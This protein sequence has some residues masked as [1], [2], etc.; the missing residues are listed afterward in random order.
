MTYTVRRSRALSILK[1]LRLAEI[2]RL[3][4]RLDAEMAKMAPLIRKGVS[5]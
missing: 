2:E 4:R 3:E 5:S 1:A